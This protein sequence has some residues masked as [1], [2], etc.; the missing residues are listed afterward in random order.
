MEQDV[1]FEAASG[2]RRW[3]TPEDIEALLVFAGRASLGAQWL[4]QDAIESICDRTGA[5]LPEEHP[6]RRL[7]EVPVPDGDEVKIVASTALQR[8][9]GEPLAEVDGH[10]VAKAPCDS[11]VVAIDGDESGRSRRVVLRRVALPSPATP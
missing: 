7:V 2:L 5:P 6:G 11:V 9:S 4:A 10:V 8:R 1:G 3:G